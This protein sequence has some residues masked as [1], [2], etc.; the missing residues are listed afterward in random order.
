MSSTTSPICRH[1]GASLPASSRFCTRCGAPVGVLPRDEMLIPGGK[2]LRVTQETLSLRELQTMIE[3][4]VHWWQQQLRSTD[5][6]TRRHAAAAIKDLSRILDSLSEQLAQGRETVRITTR[7]PVA[8]RYSVGCP[9]CGRG[10]RA[11]ARFCIACG[12]LLPDTHDVQG[13][14]TE[15]PEPLRLHAA[16]LSDVGRVRR[17]NEDT[18]AVE[19]I[20]SVGGAVAHMLLVA[21][22]MGG[23]H[24]GEVAGRLACETVQQTLR[25]EL[26]VLLP[27]DDT[28]W[29]DLLR[30]ALLA[31]NRR[32]YGAAQAQVEQQGMGT[33]LTLIV[34]VGDRAHMAHVGDSRA[35]LFNAAGVTDEGEPLLQ[36]S[37]DHT[38]VARLVDIGQLT[39]EQS[40]THPHRNV[41]YRA[42]GTEPTIDVDTGSHALRVGDRLLLCSD[43]LT[44][45]I[46][47]TELAQIVLEAAPPRDT[48][49]RLVTLANER[50]GQDNISVIVATVEGAS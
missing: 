1:C 24:A 47:D 36:L 17:N 25:T 39:P 8:R 34:V 2:R 10:N 31:A 3:S 41:L 32:V 28:A 46:E 45:Y 16:V 4:G 20:T 35:Y 21:D 29:Q 5:Q 9:I 19:P 11:G 6:V 38:L 33:T 49:R 23:A 15:Q 50:G 43:G 14:C 7:L 37:S 30:R 22:G 26:Q 42:L 40:R 27:A 44:T 12:S 18:C 13:A 48:C